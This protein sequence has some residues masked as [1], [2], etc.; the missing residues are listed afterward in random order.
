MVARLA[1]AL[2]LLLPGF[3]RAQSVDPITGQKINPVLARAAKAFQAGDME[4]ACADAT[5]AAK[6]DP[7]D[8]KAGGLAKLACEK[9]KNGLKFKGLTIQRH[10]IGPQPQDSRPPAPGSA[11]LQPQMGQEGNASP[12]V[13]AAPQDVGSAPVVIPATP[14]NTIKEEV[15]S[16]GKTIEAQDQINRG[17]YAEAISAAALAITLDP[18]NMRAHVIL[19]AAY[20]DSGEPQ[21]SF[22]A[23]EAG[24]KV[25]PENLALLKNKSAAQIK[26]GDFAGAVATAELALKTNATDPLPHAL[27]AF[28]LGRKGDRDAMF[29]A[30]KT[31]SALDPAYER[32]LL[33]AEKSKEDSLNP[34]DLP[35]EVQARPAGLPL[36][37]KPS[38]DRVKKMFLF[39]VLLI[40]F[41]VVVVML[42]YSLIS[43][44]SQ[45]AEAA[46]S[47]AKTES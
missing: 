30:L 31:A 42:L 46:A 19:A 33:Q 7:S 44:R 22:D 29:N 5:E 47:A 1:L 28:A 20:H 23:A 11:Q 9:M 37:K 36:H 32:L 18:R 12:N 3:A 14:L 17:H 15:T 21:K 45:Q 13:G 40:V 39:F 27:R 2:A 41:A 38:E 26:L 35:G 6:Q 24:L 10:P 43:Y 34:F 16:Y 8:Q 4:A 25:N